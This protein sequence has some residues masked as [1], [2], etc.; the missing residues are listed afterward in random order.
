M[1]VSAEPQPPLVTAS[2]VGVLRAR[3]WLIRGVDL[4][5]RAGEIV[6]LIGPNGAGK[7]TLAKVILGILEP[8]EGHIARAA[9][10]TVG[11]VPQR[12]SIDWTLPLSVA[13][14]MTLTS[15]LP[16]SAIAEALTAV[17][18]DGL[19]DRPVQAL[20]GGEFQRALLAR[21]IARKPRLLVLDEPVQGV[22]FSG[23]VALYRLI[24]A[25]RDL[26][27]AGILLISHDL[28]IVM[29]EADRVVCLSGHVCCEGT[30]QSVSENPEYV[31]LF[32]RQ[33]A[34]TIAL[35]RHR[36]DHTHLPDGTAVP[37]APHHHAHHGHDRP[38][39]E[40]SDAR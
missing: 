6:T 30:P 23:E 13:R 14:L 15:S 8:D 24:G 20:S 16:S 12:L 25:I 19:A 40:K 22:D 4:T 26:T 11:Y 29:A 9:G 33:A 10:L 36:H 31:R 35:Y 1:T 3:R 38:E 28:H 27:G 17:G 2:S 7:T 18:L 34:E 21:A 5:V 39:T 32:G 37:A